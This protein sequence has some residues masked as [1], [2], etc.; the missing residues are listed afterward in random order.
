MAF[1]CCKL[2]VYVCNSFFLTDGYFFLGMYSV[3]PYH[4]GSQFPR[5]LSVFPKKLEIV[6]SNPERSHFISRTRV[7]TFG[8]SQGVVR[9]LQRGMI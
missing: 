5:T 4:D 8:R 7:C 6:G 3:L 2:C 1:A 9:I